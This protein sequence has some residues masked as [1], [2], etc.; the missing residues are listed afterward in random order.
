M[1]EKQG[2]INKIPK[3]NASEQYPL[4]KLRVRA[5]LDKDEVSDALIPV[6]EASAQ[7]AAW[8]KRNAKAEAI[9]TLTLGNAAIITIAY[10][11]EATAA[12]IWK[13]LQKEFQPNQFIPR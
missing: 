9:I 4:W 13:T 5:L 7:T 3:L 6:G 11:E 10:E 8:K 12:D 2:G 1:E